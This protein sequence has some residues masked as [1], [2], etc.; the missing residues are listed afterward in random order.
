[1]GVSQQ[2]DRMLK[3]GFIL[4]TV[5]LLV[6]SAWA[7]TYYDS[8]SSELAVKNQEVLRLHAIALAEN[9]TVLQLQMQIVSI[10]ANVSI[11]NQR[12]VTL[13]QERA[14][15]NVLIANLTGQVQALKNQSAWLSLELAAVEGIG[16]L[17]VSVLVANDTIT[18]PTNS[19]IAITSQANSHNGTL[20]FLSPAGCPISGQ[21]VQS[22]SSQYVLHIQ[23]SPGASLSRSSYYTVG[24]VPFSVYYD[25]VGS[26]PV[27]CTFSL[28]YVQ[29]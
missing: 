15:S 21:T 2:P 28:L 23:F 14:A 25:D 4:V 3:V 16:K 12:I 24:S 29:P 1:M 19:S 11:L 20:A 8:S 18:L 6:V 13:L 5:A 9:I 7:V 27:E 17:S 10:G 26:S 22:T